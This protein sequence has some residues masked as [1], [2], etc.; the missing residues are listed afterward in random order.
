MKVNKI[1]ALKLLLSLLIIVGF[2]SCSKKSDSKGG[3]KAT[4]W[5][6]NDKKGGF[7]YASKFKKQATGPGLVLVEG[8]TFTMGKVADDVMHDWNNTPN[9]QHVMSFYMDETEVTNMM[10]MEYLSWLKTVFPPDQDNYKNIYEGASP[11]TLV[12][13]NRLGYNETM[14]NNYLRH[15]AY[16]E[17]PVVGVNWIQATEFAKWRTDRVNE[18]I[19]EEQ[20]YLKKDAKVTDVTA[21]KVFSTEAYLASPSTA[22]GGDQAIVLQKGQ[23]R[24]A[25][26]PN[27]NAAAGANNTAGN[28]AKNVY[29]QRTSGLILPEYRLPTEAE[30]EYAAAADVGQREYNAYKGQKKYPW[31]GTYTRSGKRQ[32]R[33]DQLANFKQGKGDYGGIAGWSDDGADIT[34]KVKSYPPNDFGLYDMA[35]NVAE[36]V[37]DVYRPIVDDEANDFNY[38][39][40][41]VYM[42]NKIGDD[43]KVE[44][45][46]A[47][48][49]QFDTLSNGKIVSRNFPGQIAQVPVDDKETYLRQN[50]DKSDNRNYRDGDKQSTRYFKFG[51]AEE[52]D[53]KGKM[54]DDQRMYDSPKHNV[55]VDSLGNMVKKYDKSSKRTTLINDDVRVYKGGSWRDRAYWLDPAQRRYFPQ[56]IATDFI[57]F[58]CAMSRVGPKADKKKRPR[59]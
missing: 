19:L 20:R 2:T 58:R 40:G 50:F 33:G 32:V 14:T 36:W 43:G 49:Q 47:E 52:G 11:D 12:W 25:A 45:V 41:N 17:Y 54:K 44:L 48:S 30:W 3:S 35:G 34:N 22:M 7:Q 27:N 42:K 4:G 56:D 38:Y 6:V 55:S 1:I 21:D 51:S 23:G 59:N 29:A 15:P 10:Y 53:E 16:A 37:A 28:S 5:K 39:R 46:T 31:S 24:G 13:R 18:K 8:G 57:G 9:Q 26:R